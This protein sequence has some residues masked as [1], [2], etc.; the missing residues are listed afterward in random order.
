MEFQEMNRE[1]CAEA[2]DKAGYKAFLSF[3]RH[4]Y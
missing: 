2:I 4:A 3:V 1:E